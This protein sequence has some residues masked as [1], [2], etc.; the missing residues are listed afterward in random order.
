MGFMHVSRELETVDRS[1]FATL[2]R[3]RWWVVTLA[4]LL[5]GLVVGGLFAFQAM[6]APA[7]AGAAVHGVGPR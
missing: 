6:R 5:A 4:V 7:G 2:T 3:G 1:V